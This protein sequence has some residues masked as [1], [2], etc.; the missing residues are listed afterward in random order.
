[1][2][3]PNPIEIFQKEAPEI[4]SAYD[5]LIQTLIQTK[6]LEPKIK[7]LIYIGIKAAMGDSLALKF[8]LDSK[9]D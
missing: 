6:A 1:M 9:K 5:G 7:Q 3:E 4:A 2:A 8:I